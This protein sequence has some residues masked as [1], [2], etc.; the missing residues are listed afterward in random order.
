MKI[1]EFMQ[2][3]FDWTD[4]VREHYDV[5][6]DTLKAGNPDAELGDKVAVAMFATPDVIRSAAEWG[7]KL[8]IVHEPVFYDHW[9]SMDTFREQTGFKRMILDKKLE[10][11]EKSGLTIFRYHD[12]PHKRVPDM[13]SEGE[14]KYFGL[15]GIWQQGKHY[16]VNHFVLDTPATVKNIVQILEKH[17]NIARVRICG[18]AEDDFMV[19]T[20]GLNFGTPGHL[21]DSLEKCDIV[22]TGEIS[23]W[24]QGEFVRDCVGLGYK[25]AVLVLGHCCS[26]RDGMRLLAELIPQQEQWKHLNLSVRY[27]ESGDAYTFAD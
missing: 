13:I 25:K 22:L 19:Q 27:F 18:Y 12:H 11:I 3:V 2:E 7:A 17:L 26:E 23:E 1:A 21:E 5:T 8:L 10:L 16:A 9:D 6:C 24:M 14:C 20:I 4:P 15:K